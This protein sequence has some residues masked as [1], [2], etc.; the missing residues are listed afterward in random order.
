MLQILSN[1]VHSTVAPLV[2]AARNA[3]GA[4]LVVKTVLYHESWLELSVLVLQSCKEGVTALCSCMVWFG[5]LDNCLS[6]DRA[7]DPV[8]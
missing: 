2:D 8:Y 3:T 7:S 6:N 5:W 4:A 1:G